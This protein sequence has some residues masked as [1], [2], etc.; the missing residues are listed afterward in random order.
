[1]KLNIESPEQVESFIDL[2]KKTD[3]DIVKLCRDVIA[4]LQGSASLIPVAR[5]K[6]LA[7]KRTDEY[8]TA[9]S[10]AVA[11]AESTLICAPANGVTEEE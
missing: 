10:R 7:R 5:I 3:P 11:V 1:M 4:E 2:M 8:K 9:M 6:R